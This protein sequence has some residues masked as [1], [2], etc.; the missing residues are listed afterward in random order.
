MTF[1][2]KIQETEQQI[3]EMIHTK[4][5]KYF[6]PWHEKEFIY[7]YNAINKT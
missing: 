4:F 6:F 2:N 5:S 1:F 3:S 7:A